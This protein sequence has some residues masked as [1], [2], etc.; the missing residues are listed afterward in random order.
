[1]N[2]PSNGVFADNSRYPQTYRFPDFFY[3]ALSSQR[4]GALHHAIAGKVLI[5][6]M[7]V[8]REHLRCAKHRA[9]A[10]EVLRKNRFAGAPESLRSYSTKKANHAPRSN[11]GSRKAT[12]R[13]PESSKQRIQCALG[14]RRRIVRSAGQ[15]LRW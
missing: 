10:S 13:R 2:S 15:L 9:N 3:R 12:G 14:Q 11:K 5:L 7:L 1:M 6:G 8:A 4:R